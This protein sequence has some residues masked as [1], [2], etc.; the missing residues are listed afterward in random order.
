[1]MSSVNYEIELEPAA[2]SLKPVDTCFVGSPCGWPF[3][4][5]MR[6][7]ARSEQVFFFYDVAPSLTNDNWQLL[8]VSLN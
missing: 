2:Q 4:Q 8:S 6:T 1:M 5:L 3:E 7:A